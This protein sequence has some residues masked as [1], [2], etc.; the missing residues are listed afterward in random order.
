MFAFD[1]KRTFRKDR[2]GAL[3]AKRDEG[4]DEIY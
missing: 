1:P 3:G 2:R 4:L